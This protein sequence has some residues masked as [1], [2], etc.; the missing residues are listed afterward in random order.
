MEPEGYQLLLTAAVLTVVAEALTMI[1]T[2]M[3]DIIVGAI[4]GGTKVN[5]GADAGE[6]ADTMAVKNGE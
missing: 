3:V 6:N 5:I 2:A 1:A 4:V